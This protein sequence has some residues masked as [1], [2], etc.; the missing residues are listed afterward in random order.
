[1]IHLEH[2]TSEYHR[3]RLVRGEKRNRDKTSQGAKKEKRRNLCTPWLVFQYQLDVD[4]C[5]MR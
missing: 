2:G 1:M 3:L 5:E 4:I